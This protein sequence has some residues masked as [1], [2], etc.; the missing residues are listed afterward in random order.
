MYFYVCQVCLQL[1]SECTK[2]VF[3]YFF[4]FY[5][6]TGG[7]THGQNLSLFKY[8]LAVPGR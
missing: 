8:E 5:I 6:M 4:Q 3:E 2:V 7:G 1:I